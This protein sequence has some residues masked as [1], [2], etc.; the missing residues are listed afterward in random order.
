MLIEAWEAYAAR[1]ANAANDNVAKTLEVCCPL[2][3]ALSV[4]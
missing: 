4:H 2:F 1:L 3:V